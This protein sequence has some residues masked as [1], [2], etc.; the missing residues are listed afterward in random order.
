MALHISFIVGGIIILIELIFSLCNSRNAS[1]F[2]YYLCRPF[3][4]SF[5]MLLGTIIRIILIMAGTIG[6]WTG[7]KYFL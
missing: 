2:T 5:S 1:D 7:I 6:L 3:G 4:F